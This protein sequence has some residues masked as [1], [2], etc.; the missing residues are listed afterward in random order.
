MGI[1]D[2]LIDFLVVLGLLVPPIAGVYLCD[3]FLLGRRDF[4][5]ENLEERPPIRVNAV[6]AGIGAGL[7]SAWMYYTGKSLTS[8]GSIDSLLISI[9]AYLA[10]EKAGTMRRSN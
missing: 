9:V 2:R 7:V 8:I 10:L 5:A 6:A 4:S 3:F 1:A